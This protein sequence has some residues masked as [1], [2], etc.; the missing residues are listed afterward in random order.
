MR[1]SSA[2]SGSSITITDTLKNIGAAD[3]PST[4]I[5][6]Y[7]SVNL[8]LDS[9]DVQ[10]DAVRGVPLLAPNISNTG[11]ATVPLP[12]GTTG[13]FY[14]LVVADGAQSV[15]ESNESNNV[16]ARFIQIASGS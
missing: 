4:V 1:R 7:L 8:M 15:A 2:L 3:A 11:S 12:A 10:L 5:R 13:N 9:S 16:V 14:V 6:Y